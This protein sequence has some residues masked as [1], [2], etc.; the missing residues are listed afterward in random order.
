MSFC[1]CLFVPFPRQATSH[2][3]SESVWVA[4]NV[5]TLL[6]EEGVNCPERVSLG[7]HQFDRRHYRIGWMLSGW[8]EGLDRCNE[9]VSGHFFAAFFWVSD[10]LSKKR[11]AASRMIKATE[12]RSFFA[13]FTIFSC[14][15]FSIGTV[16][17]VIGFLFKV[18]VTHELHCG[19]TINPVVGC[20][21]LNTI[22]QVVLHWDSHP[23]LVR[24]SFIGHV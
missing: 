22:K 1:C 13:A 7:P 20:I 3:G 12:R 6:D 10:T 2:C 8:R 18:K 19:H 11:A 24:C 14:M 5:G 15:D 21:F 4:V 23:D 17:F 9:L 16:I